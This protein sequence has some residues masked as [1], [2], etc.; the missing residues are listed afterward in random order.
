VK[1]GTNVASLVKKFLSA[2]KIPDP[3]IR[4]RVLLGVAAELTEK[5]KTEVRKE[6]SA[7][8]ARYVELAAPPVIMDNWLSQ[9]EA[10]EKILSRKLVN[11]K[12]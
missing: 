1:G 4:A 12:K 8:T 9:V 2:R 11:R 10:L 5:D 6:L 7:V 3:G